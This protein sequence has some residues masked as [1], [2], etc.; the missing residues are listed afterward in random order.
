MIKYISTADQLVD[1]FT[2]SLPSPRFHSLLTKL[3]GV[4]PLC[5]ED[6]KIKDKEQINTV[7][8]VLKTTCSLDTKA[9]CNLG[10]L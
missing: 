1:L 3:M 2:K 10:T 8:K 7:A 9:G 5:F 4:P 6:V